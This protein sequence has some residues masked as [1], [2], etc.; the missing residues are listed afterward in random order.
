MLTQPTEHQL[1]IQS[2]TISMRI[3]LLLLNLRMQL[4]EMKTNRNLY[5][6]LISTQINY[7]T[8]QRDLSKKIFTIIII[9]LLQKNKLI[10]DYRIHITMKTQQK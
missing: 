8:M 10:T 4:E 5:Q 9:I 6:N 7:K 1:S 2:L 3:T